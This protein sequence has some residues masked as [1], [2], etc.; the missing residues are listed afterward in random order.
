MSQIAMHAPCDEARV[1]DQFCSWLVAD[2][3]SVEREVKFVDVLA[4]R[5]DVT[6][7]GEAN[8]RTAAA[9]L[10]VDTHFTAR[11]CV[12]C[13]NNGERRTASQS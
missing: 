7:Y 12:A 1:I 3:W 4:R 2:G 11:C 6:Q 10:D 5:N 13:P 8:G 9:G